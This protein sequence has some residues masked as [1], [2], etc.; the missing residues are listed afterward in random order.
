MLKT[1]QAIRIVYTGVS[2]GGHT[3][4]GIYPGTGSTII[5]LS[6]DVIPHGPGSVDQ[7]QAG[8]ISK[9]GIGAIAESADLRRGGDMASLAGIDV[10]LRNADRLFLT[11]KSGGVTLQG[12][13]VELHE[14]EWNATAPGTPSESGGTMTNTTIFTGIVDDVQWDAL[15]LVLKL[16]NSRYRRNAMVGTIIDNGN[17]TDVSQIIADIQA[18]NQRGN[19]PYADSAQNGQI[20]PC[21]FGA[22][23]FNGTVGTEDE[24]SLAP[25]KMIRTAKLSYPFTVNGSKK[26]TISS[27]DYYATLFSKPGDQT[28]YRWIVLAPAST[29]ANFDCGDIYAFP[30]TGNTGTVTTPVRTETYQVLFTP[31]AGWWE[32]SHNYGAAGSWGNLSTGNYA[33]S[34][35][36][37]IAGTY[38]QTIEGTGSD[39]SRL[40]TSATPNNSSSINVVLTEP[41]YTAINVSTSPYTWAQFMNITMEYT[42][43]AWPGAGW[44]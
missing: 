3:D 15:G 39:Q 14:F 7:Y 17:Y 6:E 2:L 21:T 10:T 36:T 26:I 40:I 38:M 1:I 32:V 37:A 16:K 35:L 33:T 41:F 23:P 24:S 18:G 44:L 42:A 12:C 4:L 25:A 9:G 11:L 5:R 31:G 20:V 28:Q 13:P 22:F 19:Y 43:D 27:A 8:F 29:T 34:N 30:V